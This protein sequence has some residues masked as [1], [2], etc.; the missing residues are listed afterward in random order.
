MKSSQIL[1]SILLMALLNSCVSYYYVVTDV[2][3]NLSVCR[4][5][6]ANSSEG[7]PADMS[8]MPADRWSRAEYVDPF[9][10]DFHYEV[11]DLNEKSRAEAEDISSI[12]FSPDSSQLMNPLFSP[13]ERLDKRFRWFYTYYDY[14]TRFGS[15]A[16][17]LPLPFE[18]YVTP[19]QASLFLRGQDPPEGWNGLEMYVLLDD[20][21]RCFFTWYADAVFFTM[22]DLF[23]PYCS[24]SQNAF[25]DACKPA[26]ADG[27]DEESIIIM[28]PDDFAARLDAIAPDAGFGEVYARNAE[29]LADEYADRSELVSYFNYSFLYRISLPGRYF[30][31]NAVDFIDGD[32][33]WRVD[34]FRLM[35]GELVLEATSRT[36]NVWAFVL[37]FAL[38]L[39]FLQVFAKLFSKK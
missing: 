13:L 4:E 34:A 1:L 6:Y 20:V 26:F 36:L 3:K 22:C 37:T 16:P 8:F 2:D 15:V 38:V 33:V 32:P 30:E 29:A 21:N 35:G 5:V 14:S 25:L 19:E 39:L 27:I 18:G 7:S 24:K 10:V 9:K 11:I 31:G 28:E 17:M 23:D 12:A